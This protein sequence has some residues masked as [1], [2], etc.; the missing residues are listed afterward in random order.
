MY[1]FFVKITIFFKIQLSLVTLFPQ[2][3]VNL[4]I[5][6]LDCREFSKPAKYFEYFEY[7]PSA[8]ERTK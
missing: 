3:V 7:F 5:E 2:L 8:L 4:L 1:N 6:L